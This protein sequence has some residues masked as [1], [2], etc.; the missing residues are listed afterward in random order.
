MRLTSFCSEKNG[1]LYKGNNQPS[2][3]FKTIKN[4]KNCISVRNLFFFSVT[5]YFALALYRCR[6]VTLNA[7]PVFRVRPTPL[8]DYVLFLFFALISWFFDIFSEI[9]WFLGEYW[10][11]NAQLIYSVFRVWICLLC[12][13]WF[14][15]ITMLI[16]RLFYVLIY[17]LWWIHS[18]G[19]VLR[20][21]SN[22]RWWDIWIIV[23]N[24][25][26]V[27]EA[28]FC[29]LKF[30]KLHV[31]LASIFSL[32]YFVF[33]SLQSTWWFL[34]RGAREGLREGTSTK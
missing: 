5:E 17:L 33:P 31:F 2:P 27:V 19:F 3:I 13:R 23:G 7:S 32:P 6:F 25:M 28:L 22:W 30:V 15:S 14:W 16:S 20:F 9:R 18:E 12:N 11:L 34:S 1:G 10:W 21:L 24:Q 26:I 8:S 4:K 29:F